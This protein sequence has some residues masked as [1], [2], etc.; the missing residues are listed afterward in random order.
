MNLSY[1]RSFKIFQSVRNLLLPS[2]EQYLYVLNFII[3]ELDKYLCCKEKE[4]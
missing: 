1:L 2:I 3:L 4:N